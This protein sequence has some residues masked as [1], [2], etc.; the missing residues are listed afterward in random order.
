MRWLVKRVAPCPAVSP[1]EWSQLTED[2]RIVGV[3][4]HPD[5]EVARSFC[6]LAEADMVHT[7]FL[8]DLDMQALLGGVPDSILVV[9]HAENLTFSLPLDD[10]S[11]TRDMELFIQSR[12][13]PLLGNYSEE[14]MTDLIA[15][16]VTKVVLHPTHHP[17]EV[18]PVC[19][20]IRLGSQS[21]CLTSGLSQSSQYPRCCH[22]RKAELL[23][24]MVISSHCYKIRLIFL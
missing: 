6:H 18:K 14:V 7:Y 3:F 19:R 1:G 22:R 24:H 5:S 15:S 2:T 10:S 9:K 4:S 13:S 20:C 8:A 12:G 11:S 23:N 16:K 21:R 17:L